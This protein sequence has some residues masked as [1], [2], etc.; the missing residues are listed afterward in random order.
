MKQKFITYKKF[1]KKQIREQQL[2]SEDFFLH[3]LISFFT[4]SKS[5][6]KRKF[7]GTFIAKS[8]RK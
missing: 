3:R 2:F 8:A 5:E 1:S 6:T 4:P 7:T